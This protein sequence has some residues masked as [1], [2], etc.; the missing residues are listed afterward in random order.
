M[1]QV[2]SVRGPIGSSCLGTTRM[3]EHVFVFDT[4]ILENCP[5][6]WGEE[7]KRVADA[8]ARLNERGWTS[9]GFFAKKKWICRGW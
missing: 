1:P 4:E 9:S 8:I 2:Q 6:D 5:D 3:H 7:K